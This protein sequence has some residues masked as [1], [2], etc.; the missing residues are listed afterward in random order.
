[1]QRILGR[2]ALVAAVAG[3]ALAAG[4]AQGGTVTA[5][6]CSQEDVQA[7]ADVARDGDVVLVPEGTATWRTLAVRTPAVRIAGKGLTLQGAGADKT[8][9]ADETG[10]LANE[11]PLSVT[12]SADRPVRVTGFTFRG[13]KRRSSAEPGLLISGTSWRV[14]HCKFDATDTKGRGIWGGTQGLIDN[15]AF[16]NCTQGVAVMG[17]GDASWARRLG[18]GTPDAVYIEDCLFEYTQWG[19]SAIDAYNGARYVFRHNVVGGSNVGH[20]GFDSGG[21]R[22]TF[23]FEIYDNKL[24]GR[25]MPSQGRAMHFR[26]GTGVVSGNELLNYTSGIGLANYRSIEANANLVGQWGLADGKNPLDG[27]E[28]PNGY[29]C[30]E[31]VGRSTNQMLEP[32]YVW[33][34]TFG[35]GALPVGVSDG[36]KGVIKE[37]RDYLLDTPRPGYKPYTYPHP[38]R[39]RFPPRSAEAAPPGAPRNLVA[40]AAAERAVALSWDPPEG[41]GAVAGYYV[42]RD[43]VKLTTVSDPAYTQYTMG[44]LKAPLTQYKFAVSAYDAA[45]T[46]GAASAPAAAPDGAPG[47]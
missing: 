34:N 35:G 44:G 11:L 9:I 39:E 43:G 1:M 37:G 13:M 18:L 24:D 29:P 27:N 5:V 16:V 25:H 22:S 12:S 7:A 36:G 4:A 26:G 40:R 3:V 23:S 32:L 45:G 6:S 19:D 46:E 8:V 28:E 10:S 33:G 17:D 47:G 15:C 2:A 38:Y 14:D 31:Q 21:Y 42:W 41:G 20:H 30:R